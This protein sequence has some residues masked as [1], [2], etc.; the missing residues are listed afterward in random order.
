ML[1][2]CEAGKSSRIPSPFVIGRKNEWENSLAATTQSEYFTA[3]QKQVD[4]F[5][6]DQVECQDRCDVIERV[7]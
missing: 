7:G 4:R 6:K 3:L 5:H 1:L 2:V